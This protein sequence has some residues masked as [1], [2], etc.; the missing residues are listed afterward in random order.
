MHRHCSPHNNTHR[1][2][3][4]YPSGGGGQPHSGQAP[5]QPRRPSKLGCYGIFKHFALL[6]CRLLPQGAVPRKLEDRMRRTTNASA[7]HREVWDSSGQ[8]V[9]PNNVASKGEHRH[10]LPCKRLRPDTLS[11]AEAAEQ[12]EWYAEAAELEAAGA[13]SSE[14][15]PDG[16]T[17]AKWPPEDKP[18]LSDVMNDLL[19]LGQI[20]RRTHQIVYVFTD[21]LKD[22]LQV[23]SVHLRQH[24]L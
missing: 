11:V 10:R 13:L 3:R 17:L 9:V 19:I 20:A 18:R 6:P 21:D 7:P 15:P 23:F 8:L 24:S 1:S 22:F 5:T 14:V 4:L 2:S 12:P 16:E